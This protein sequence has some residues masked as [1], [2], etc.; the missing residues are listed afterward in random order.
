MYDDLPRP[1]DVS[2]P[3]TGFAESSYV[4]YDWDR[5]GKLSN[6]VDFFG[7]GERKTLARIEDGLGT[8]SMVTRWRAGSPDLAGTEK[9]AVKVFVDELREALG[10]QDWVITGSGTT[11]IL[12]K[13]S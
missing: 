7:G 11:I 12:C 6:G 3:V 5:D 10:G 2:P 9:D 4:K 1:W 8:A 13:K